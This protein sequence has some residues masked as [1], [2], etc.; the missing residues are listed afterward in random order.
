MQVLLLL[1]SVQPVS[2]LSKR[3]QSGA[4]CTDEMLRMA[5]IVDIRRSKPILIIC[6]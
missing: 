1:P 6:C 2:F 3:K 5:K 4:A